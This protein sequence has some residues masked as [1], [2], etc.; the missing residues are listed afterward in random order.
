MFCPIHVFRHDPGDHRV[1]C[2][3]LQ[4][5]V[6]GTEAEQEEGSRGYVLCLLYFLLSGGA[7]G[8]PWLAIVIVAMGGHAHSAMARSLR[9]V[10]SALRIAS[11]AYI[12]ARRLSR[13]LIDAVW[14]PL[15]S[16]A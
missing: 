3:A 10:Y 12:G 1:A 11:F 6:K 16:L 13:S 5:V 14:N 4:G 2:G 15:F 9:A 8:I 7:F